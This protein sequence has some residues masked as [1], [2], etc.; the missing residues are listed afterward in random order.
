MSHLPCAASFDVNA[1]TRRPEARSSLPIFVISLCRRT[2]RRQHMQALLDQVGLRAEFIDAVD[3]KR[4]TPEQ[5]ATYDRKKALLVY[6][7]EMSPAE[8][9]CH[10]S[11][12]S[13]YRRMVEHGV[14]VALVLEDDIAC[15][16]DLPQLLDEVLSETNSPW[17]VLRLQS[18]KTTIINHERPASRGEI[19]SQHRGRAIG[20][21]RTGV[22]GGC[23]Y[24][25]KLSAAKR[26]LSYA[27]RP[28]MPIDQTLDR[29]WENGILP[30][31]LRPFPI[32]QNE[33]IASEIGDRK[34]KPRLGRM[35]T[36]ARR[37]RRAFDGLNK[38]RYHFTHM[39]GVRR[40]SETAV[41]G[42]LRRLVHAVLG[43][44]AAG[45]KVLPQ[46]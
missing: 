7:V 33:A 19:L 25:I 9:A 8:I 37:A 1:A 31:V 42:P 3:G 34:H 46:R 6:G 28:F 18:T 23:G 21:L 11:H 40:L 4:L 39:G 32:W 29:Y 22:L 43:L 10:L 24:L 16:A 45:S 15:D 14:D 26:M 30:Y 36:L 13:I 5:Y 20:R 2:D 44:T 17:E 41:A 35:L 27:E 12:L 38:R